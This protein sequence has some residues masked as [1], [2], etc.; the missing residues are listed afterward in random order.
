MFS[1]YRTWDLRDG[2]VLSERELL[3]LMAAAIAPG[4]AHDSC[5]SMDDSIYRAQKSVNLA[6]AILSEIDSDRDAKLRAALSRLMAS[7]IRDGGDLV[8]A[9]A[10]AL[11]LQ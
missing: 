2:G 8:P 11:G 10:K 9:M 7:V 1:T 4:F 5:D 3:S 6:R